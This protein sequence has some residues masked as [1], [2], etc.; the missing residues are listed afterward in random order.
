MRTMVL[1]SRRMFCDLTAKN[2]KFMRKV[3][4]YEKDFYIHQKA[5]QITDEKLSEFVANTPREKIAHEMATSSSYDKEMKDFIGK[6][7]LKHKN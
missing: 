2:K 1:I 4:R 6:F 7:N 3:G 5:S